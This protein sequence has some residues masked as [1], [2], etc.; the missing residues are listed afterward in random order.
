MPT[1]ETRKKNLWGSR[2]TTS[3]CD[4]IFDS[5]GNCAITDEQFAELTQ[6]K[7]AHLQLFKSSS[8]VESNDIGKPEINDIGSSDITDIGIP[9]NIEDSN[10]IEKS[11]DD[12]DIEEDIEDDEEASLKKQLSG[13]KVVDLRQIAR[14]LNLDETVINSSKKKELVD[15]ILDNA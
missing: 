13:K 2:I 15:Y 1:I 4:L 3:V 6:P 5:K 7:H 9:D 12:E 14:S 11:D 8:K 10:N